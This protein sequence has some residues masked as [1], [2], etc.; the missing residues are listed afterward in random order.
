MNTKTAKQISIR[1]LPTSAYTAQ[2]TI[3]GKRFN[4]YGKT[5][6]EVRRKLADA[7]KERVAA[8]SKH[9]VNYA[10]KR[11]STV[12]EWL[13]IWLRDYV[14]PSVRSSTYNGYQG[15]LRNHVNPQIGSKKLASLDPQLLQ[16]F[17]NGLQKKLSAKTITNIRN[18]LHSSFLPPA[19]AD[20]CCIHHCKGFGSLRHSSWKCVC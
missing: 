19:P 3:D 18:M 4:F 6:A 2:L 14:A 1:Q 11:N 15:M 8:A 12:E 7:E 16:Q 17:F 13:E 20:I 5:K 9:I 10:N